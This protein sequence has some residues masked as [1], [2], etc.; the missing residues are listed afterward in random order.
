M[1]CDVKVD[2]ISNIGSHLVVFETKDQRLDL[3]S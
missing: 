3:S 1:E 2:N